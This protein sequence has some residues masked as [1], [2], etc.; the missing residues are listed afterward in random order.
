[1]RRSLTVTLPIYVPSDRDPMA[2]IG[3]NFEPES[4]TCQKK[5]KKFQMLYMF[6]LVF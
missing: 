3:I 1:M 4:Q 5:L 6:H 2:M